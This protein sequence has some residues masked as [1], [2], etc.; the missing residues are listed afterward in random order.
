MRTGRGSGTPEGYP[1]SVKSG[2]EHRRRGCRDGILQTSFVQLLTLTSM[3][4]LQHQ[5]L[6]PTATL[7]LAMLCGIGGLPAY[8]AACAQVS[9]P[10][11]VVQPGGEVCPA[12]QKKGCECCAP[13]VRAAGCHA[14]Q[15]AGGGVNAAPRCGCTL[16]APVNVPPATKAA[17]L[18]TSTL[19]S[20]LLP[21]TVIHFARASAGSELPD[22]D[23]GPPP[24]DYRSSAP[25]R[26]PPAP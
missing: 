3:R 23:D 10:A 4:S 12:S 5:R 20:A 1:G 6:W 13:A 7:L 11:S 15:T 14:A 21:V 8:A 17:G 24:S 22:G 19:V 16:D 18:H 9:A 2:M 25:S 26:A